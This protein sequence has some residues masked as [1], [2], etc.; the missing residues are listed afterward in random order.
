MDICETVL[1]LHATAITYCSYSLVITQDF[2]HALKDS[3]TLIK[4]HWKKTMFLWKINGKSHPLNLV[5]VLISVFT[6]FRYC[7][8]RCGCRVGKTG[9]R[10]K[11]RGKTGWRYSLLRIDLEQTSFRMLFLHLPQYNGILS[12]FCPT[13]VGISSHGL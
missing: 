5:P 13:M 9:C 10:E 7:D 1:V 12:N 11:G 6:V 4:C 3:V 8:S 2:L